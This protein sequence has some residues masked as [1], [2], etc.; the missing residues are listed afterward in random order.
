MVEGKISDFRSLHPHKFRLM[1]GEGVQDYG[2]HGDNR[3]IDEDKCKT[4]QNHIL[5]FLE[6]GLY[7]IPVFHNSLPLMD[8]RSGGDPSTAPPD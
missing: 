3:Q 5:R 2:N 8:M 1:N 6:K 7:L 4:Q